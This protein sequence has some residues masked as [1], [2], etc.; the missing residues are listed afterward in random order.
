MKPTLEEVQDYFKDAEIVRS[1]LRSE[2]TGVSNIH[3]ENDMYWCTAEN[4]SNYCLWKDDNYAKILKTKTMKLEVT[5][6]TI[7]SYHKDACQ[8]LQRKKF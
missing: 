8:S 3:E 5:E 6:E 7:K 2:F 1:C 4:N